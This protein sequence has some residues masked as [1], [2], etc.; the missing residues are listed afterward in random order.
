MEV[1]ARSYVKAAPDRCI[2]GSDWP[3]ASATAGMQA[4]PDDAHLLDL[5][6]TWIE[7]DA[8]FQRILVENPSTLYQY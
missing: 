2:W 1:L 3:H 8:T 4:I 5:L 6:S 7:D